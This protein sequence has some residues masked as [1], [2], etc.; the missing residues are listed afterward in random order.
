M[1]ELQKYI[2]ESI[3]K[4]DKLLLQTLREVLDAKQKKQKKKRW[5]QFSK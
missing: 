2:D 5:W 4:R 3:K 1:K